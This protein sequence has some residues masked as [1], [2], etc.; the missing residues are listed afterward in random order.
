MQG[1]SASVQKGDSQPVFSLT[2]CKTLRSSGPKVYVQNTVISG[3]R[4]IAEAV[5]G[6]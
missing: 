3:F 5:R 1:V 4:V 6:N 2:L